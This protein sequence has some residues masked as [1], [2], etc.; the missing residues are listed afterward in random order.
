[1][2]AK[3]VLV[4]GAGLQGTAAV[5]A[6]VAQPEVAQVWVVD[7]RAAALD[8][9]QRRVASPKVRVLAADV[10]AADALAPAW[11]A[12]VA[13]VIG[14]VPPAQRLA[15]AQAAVARG[16]HYVDASYPLPEFT[17]LGAHAAAR[18]VALLPE[19]GLDPGLDLILSQVLL[20][21]LDRVRLWRVFGAGIP[22]PAAATPPLRYKISWTFEGVLRAYRRPARVIEHGQ[23]VDIPPAALFSP[24]HCF[25]YT[26]PGLGALEAYPN[27]DVTR[28][29][30]ALGPQADV[31]TAG[32][33]SLRWPGHCALWRAWGQLG[34][35]D[36]QPIAVDGT[37]VAPARFLQ[38]LLEPQ[39]Q[40]APHER[41]IALVR[42]EVAGE[43]DGHPV[44]RAAQ[45]LD[46]RDL[47]TG[48]LAMQRTVGFTAAAGAWLLLTG[49]ITARGLLSP[50]R[51]VPPRALL[52]ALAPHGLQVTWEGVDGPTA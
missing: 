38:A 12:G 17:A 11:D 46:Y 6:L 9:L 26:V 34:F 25:T 22:E 7:R 43:Q 1:M 28:Y 45:L 52:Q 35:L 19:M 2:N 23:V 15:L 37:P 30:R 42:V 4:A 27:G 39:L 29:V 24:E 44:R 21:N 40:Y 14:L 50:L 49:R 33:Y 48:L 10:D 18:G 51:H 31:C 8:A 20:R 47:N 41:D 16:V 36:P 32:R 13:V 3:S 5:Y